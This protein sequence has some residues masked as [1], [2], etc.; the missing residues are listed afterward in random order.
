MAGFGFLASLRQDLHC[1]AR[2][3]A[4]RPGFSAAIVLTV[5]LGVGANTALFSVVRAVL[6][7]RLGYSDPQLVIVPSACHAPRKLTQIFV[8]YVQPG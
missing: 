5:A 2:L 6:L 1:A 8:R 3:I 4:K 7:R